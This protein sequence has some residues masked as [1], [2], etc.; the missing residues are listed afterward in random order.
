MPEFRVPEKPDHVWMIGYI[1]LSWSHIETMLEF[2]ICHYVGV[3]TD[4][5]L[6]L[7]ANIG[8]FSRLDLL[9]IALNSKDT[10]A[11]EDKG[12]LKTLISDTNDA[13]RIRNVAAHANWSATEDPMICRKMAIRAKGKRLQLIDE[14]VHLR[15]LVNDAD[16]VYQLGRRWHDFLVRI[17]IEETVKGKSTSKND[18]DR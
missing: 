9:R 6:V 1:V 11:E 3:G 17:G 13:Y 10:V 16:V 15:D 12:D 8:F 7:T 4:K 5:G 2:T 14:P 18:K